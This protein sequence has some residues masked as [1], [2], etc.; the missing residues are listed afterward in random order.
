MENL[1]R[2]IMINAPGDVALREVPPPEVRPGE[3][4]IRVRAM[5]VCGSDVA[6]FNGINPLVSYPRI[7]GHEAAGTVVES[8][9]GD[10]G[11]APGDRVVLEP[12]VACG[13]CYPC[14][15]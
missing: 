2:A 11:F 8:S 4:L 6:A 10:P 12:Y 14:L 15:N 3:V 13:R 1:M 5:G 7:I 9:G